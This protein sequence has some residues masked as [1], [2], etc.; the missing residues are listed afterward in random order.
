MHFGCPGNAPVSSPAMQARYCLQ[1]TEGKL[2]PVFS[3][4]ISVLALFAV[5]C[6]KSP[7]LEK[8]NSFDRNGIRFEYPGNWTVME[9]EQTDVGRYIMVRTT[10]DGLTMFQYFRT[11]QFG[12]LQ[13]FASFMTKLY[14]EEFAPGAIQDLTYK[15]IDD[16]LRETHNLSQGGQTLGVVRDFFRIWSGNRW[17][18]L[19]HHI[20]RKDFQKANPG[21]ELIRKTLKTDEQAL[22][23]KN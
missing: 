18:Y 6:E 15:E 3:V 21:F 17:I 4:C 1:I 16:G 2:K 12:S 8:T 22:F 5:A 13:D 11:P 10:G 7:D 23:T 20:P 19:T 9:D 14:S